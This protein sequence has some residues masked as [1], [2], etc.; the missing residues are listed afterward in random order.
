MRDRFDQSV[1]DI[2]AA[3]RALTDWAPERP[4]RSWL[5]RVG[6]V[7][8]DLFNPVE[9]TRNVLAAADAVID[10]IGWFLDDLADLASSISGTLGFLSVAFIWAP[11]IG[12]TFAIAAL[13]TAATAA[14]GRSVAPRRSLSSMPP[15]AG[16]SCGRSGC[17][18]PTDRR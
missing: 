17:R 9:L 7:A 16:R 13:A 1:P 10:D 14:V 4:H 3:I 6:D 8:N 5:D 15:G 11:G 12:Q 18:T 2:A